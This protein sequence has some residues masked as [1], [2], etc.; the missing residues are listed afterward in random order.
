M[1]ENP[2]TF[3]NIFPL[4]KEL[5]YNEIIN[6][7][8]K[9][10]IMKKDNPLLFANGAHLSFILSGKNSEGN[11]DCPIRCRKCN[12]PFTRDTTSMK[13]TCTGKNKSDNRCGCT[14]GMTS[15]KAYLIDLLYHKRLYILKEDNNESLNKAAQE[16]PT[17]ELPTQELPTQELP[18]QEL[19][20]Q[21]LPTQEL[22]T[23]ELPTQE[24]P[25]QEQN[26][27]YVLVFTDGQPNGK[28]QTVKFYSPTFEEDIKNPKLSYPLFPTSAKVGLKKVVNLRH[29]IC[30]PFDYIHPEYEKHTKDDPFII[31]EE[32]NNNKSQIFDMFYESINSSMDSRGILD[33]YLKE[34]RKKNKRRRVEDDEPLEIDIQSHEDLNFSSMPP[35]LLHP[36]DG[37][38]IILEENS[39]PEIQTQTE[40]N[41]D[42]YN[43]LI[44]QCN[45]MKN[46]IY[47][48][49]NKLNMVQ[50][51]V[52]RTVSTVSKVTEKV[53]KNTEKIKENRVFNFNPYES[54]A[55]KAEARANSA[56][57]RRAIATYRE[58]ARKLVEEAKEE[59]R[60]KYNK[61]AQNLISNKEELP[62][63][64]REILE[65]ENGLNTIMTAY[66]GLTSKSKKEI[67]S[68][69]IIRVY[70]KGLGR[71]PTRYVR[72]TLKG[73]GIK[74]KDLKNISF[75]S[76]E[77]CELMI[78]KDYKNT[79]YATL[80]YFDGIEILE[81]FD[82]LE[83][84]SSKNE[85]RSE[86]EEAFFDRIAGIIARK[87]T[88]DYIKK[89]CLQWID[90]T[91][92]KTLDV[93]TGE[94]YDLSLEN[95]GNKKNCDA[96]NFGPT[97]VSPGVPHIFNSCNVAQ[98]A[99]HMPQEIGSTT[100]SPST[101][102]NFCFKNSS[103]T[104]LNF[105]SIMTPSNSDELVTPNA[106]IIPITPVTPTKTVLPVSPVS[107]LDKVISKKNII[108]STKNTNINDTDG[109]SIEG[110]DDDEK[111][112]SNDEDYYPSEDDD[113]EEKEGGNSNKK[114][115][116]NKKNKMDVEEE[117]LENMV[118]EDNIDNEMSLSEDNDNNEN[119]NN[120][121]IVTYVKATQ[122]ENTNKN[123]KNEI[124]N[125]NKD[126]LK[127]TKEK[128]N[129]NKLKSTSKINKINL[130]K[131][132]KLKISE[133]N[134]L[135][136]VYSSISSD[137][138]SNE[139]LNDS[140]IHDSIETTTSTITIVPTTP[141]NRTSHD[142]ELLNISSSP[143]QYDVS[144]SPCS[145][146]F[147][148]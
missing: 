118:V 77:I 84:T 109:I 53:I 27:K 96:F 116:K 145:L 43:R 105:G 39:T 72:D 52:E 89:Y 12:R 97:N 70:V 124:K 42:S 130:A 143:L 23:Q 37:N 40:F 14:I 104:P 144:S 63:S 25:A 67:S 73:F 119:N 91:K 68:D 107:P 129:K 2:I 56:S 30:C 117:I 99:P 8:N 33:G 10:Y 106:P 131:Q 31:C 148:N 138:T 82:P 66:A 136:L 16:L 64:L 100:T 110:D 19:P 5:N 15:F 22:P 1:E 59:E 41:L 54:F 120:N 26:E 141:P 142:Y 146:R 45:T 98:N 140:I 133:D 69:D 126:I 44:K 47:K 74:K 112:D 90:N 6:I 88:P 123:K 102:L 127:K 57:R 132:P 76:T 17:Q 95:L 93:N 55:R 4:C 101:P 36:C 121:N 3:K 7:N 147:D 51:R 137:G 58:R 81:N 61:I 50:G 115:N 83:Y 75:I 34:R 48:L 49:N 78:T 20:T 135:S 13:F 65:Q 29:F 94:K 32:A 125:K 85:G 92:F 62:P 111:D 108:L 128:K 21:E 46:I 18:T 24:L 113:D 122:P 60:K 28:C 9:S 71:K 87:K 134:S 38:D 114:S 35:E 79:L 139:P 103:N 80:K 86:I 11:S